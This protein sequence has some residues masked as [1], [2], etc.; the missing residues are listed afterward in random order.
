MPLT[1]VGKVPCI[2]VVQAE[3]GKIVRVA[4]G[5]PFKQCAFPGL[6]LNRLESRSQT[7]F[8]VIQHTK[9]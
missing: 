9:N 5:M 7:H 2:P 8:K 3:T 1:R 4:A 6:D